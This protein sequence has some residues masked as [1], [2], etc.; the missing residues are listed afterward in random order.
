[1]Y[2]VKLDRS[3]DDLYNEIIKWCEY[4]IGGLWELWDSAYTTDYTGCFYFFKH[5]EHAQ[6]FNSV[7]ERTAITFPYDL[8]EDFCKEP[9]GCARL[10]GLW[11][12]KHWVPQ[13]VLYGEQRCHPKVSGGR[14]HYY[15]ADGVWFFE[16]E[17]DALVY[18]IDCNG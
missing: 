2:T 5:Q 12:S 18:W 8:W 10:Q 15:V 14:H 17:V 6:H 13:T 11:K 1:M 7:W 9:A 16:F 3:K 4:S